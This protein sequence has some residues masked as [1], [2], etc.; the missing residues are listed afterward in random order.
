LKAGGDVWEAPD[1]A[2]SIETCFPFALS[3]AR[4]R[5]I[6]LERFAALSSGAAARAYGLHPRKGALLP[7]SDADLA[8]V[9]LAATWRIDAGALHVKHRWSLSEGAEVSGR[10]VATVRAGGLAYAEGEVLAPPGS[11]ELLR[12]ARTAVRSSGSAT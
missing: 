12:S 11:G 6:G 3:E 8:L 2:P 4:R 10:V 5:G 7:G 1:G 9:D